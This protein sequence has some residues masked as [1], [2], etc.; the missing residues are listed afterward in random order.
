[1]EALGARKIVIGGQTLQQAIW[2]Q[3]L[4]I[5]CTENSV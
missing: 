4:P 5:N 2:I 3:I 1:M